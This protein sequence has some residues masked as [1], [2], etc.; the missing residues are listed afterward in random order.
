MLRSG[1]GSGYYGCYNATRKT[2][3]NGLLVSRKNAEEKILMDLKER[4]L[5]PENL[6]TVYRKVEKEV[7]RNLES[8]PDSVEKIMRT[9]EKIQTEI[10]HYLDF[11]KSG[12]LSKAVAE[13][14]K[15]AEEKDEKLSQDIDSLEF[16]RKKSFRRPSKEWV[17]ARLDKFQDILRTDTISSALA[18]K[19]VLGTIRLRPIDEDQAEP[20]YIAD[21]KIQTLALLDERHNGS[22]WWQWRRG[23]DSNPRY[24]FTTVYRFSKPAH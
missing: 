1:K 24:G 10:R 23:R 12:N 20:H 5:T 17:Q 4:I 3:T 19:D 13:A 2:C 22:N 14:L 15:A 8:A 6:D 11:I 18:L 21:L 16:Q 7:I 9:R